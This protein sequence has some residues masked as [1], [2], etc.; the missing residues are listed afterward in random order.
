MSP[1]DAFQGKMAGSGNPFL[2]GLTKPFT[3]D[4]W[5]HIVMSYDGAGTYTGG[6]SRP[7]VVYINGV[8]ARRTTTTVSGRANAGQPS[9]PDANTAM[10]QVMTVVTTCYLS[11]T[12]MLFGKSTQ[13]QFY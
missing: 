9:L 2:S 7:F 8:V 4:R 11:T 13:E 12:Y 10:I 1:V 5:Y 3:D 6:A